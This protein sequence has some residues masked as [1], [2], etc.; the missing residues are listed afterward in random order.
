[1]ISHKA[2]IHDPIVN[3]SAKR[4]LMVESVA[5]LDSRLYMGVPPFP[6]EAQERTHIPLILGKGPFIP[7]TFHKLS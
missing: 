4:V 1:M 6:H 5:I 7:L 3:P 2:I